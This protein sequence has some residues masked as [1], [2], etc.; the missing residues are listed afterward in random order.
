VAG[1]HYLPR[2]EIDR[3][4]WDAAAATDA[5]GLPYGFCWWLD[6]ATR[7]R[8]DGIVLGDYQAVWPLPNTGY[9][10]RFTRVQR[11]VFTQQS[12]PFGIFSGADLPAMFNA[13]PKRINSFALPISER[14]ALTDVPTGRQA[15]YRTNLLLD[16]SP[17][18]DE[19]TAG[20]ASGLR[21][22]LRKH[23]PA[24]LESATVEEVM[25]VYQHV[26]GPKVGL[27]KKHF[28]RGRALMNA[29]LDNNAGLCVKLTDDDGTL[30][31][32]NFL[33]HYGG[34]LINLLPAST[35]AGYRREGMAR[36]LHGIITAH[37]GEGG[38]LDFEGSDVPGIATFFRQFGPVE[39]PYLSVE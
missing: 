11:A 5:T 17:G 22:K 33:P 37:A 3:N 18:V 36:L 26:V 30:L 25:D 19:L 7:G 38:L 28:T 16:L 9:F 10:G 8:W 23:G 20:Y 2:Q 29:A 21:R 39:R 27:R 35:P 6:A 31:A 4:R 32:T 34:R 12:G 15:H 13:L 24:H 14:L 1:V